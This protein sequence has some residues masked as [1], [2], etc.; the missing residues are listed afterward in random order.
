M[1]EELKS[2]DTLSTPNICELLDKNSHN[3]CWQTE[4]SLSM[5]SVVNLKRLTRHAALKPTVE[6]LIEQVSTVDRVQNFQHQLS[7]FYRTQ[8]ASVRDYFK[9]WWTR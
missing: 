1:H 6:H 2:F 7:D 3:T 5:E 8:F 9:V 4:L